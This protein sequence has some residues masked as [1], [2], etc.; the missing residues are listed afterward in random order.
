MSKTLRTDNQPSP[1]KVDHTNGIY[2]PY[3]FRT[4]MCVLLHPIR[5]RSESAVRQ[6]LE[7]LIVIQED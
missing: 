2:V 6:D 3:S 5:T 4:F 1:G 7:F